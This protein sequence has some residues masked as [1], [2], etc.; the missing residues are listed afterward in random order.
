VCR[1]AGSA[2]GTW[3]NQP[4]FS[5]YIRSSAVFDHSSVFAVRASSTSEVKYMPLAGA[6]EGCSS[7]PSGG[8]IHDTLGNDPAAMSE[9]KSLGNVGSNAFW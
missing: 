1:R 9:T 2:C 4:S 3:S 6:D 5:S 7:K 8:M